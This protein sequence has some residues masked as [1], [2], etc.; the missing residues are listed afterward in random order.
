MAT[1]PVD[2]IRVWDAEVNIMLEP[3]PLP[4]LL[5]VE[6]N[7]GYIGRAYGER[8]PA[9][10]ADKYS[11]LVFMRNTGLYDQTLAMQNRGS[12]IEIFADDLITSNSEPYLFRVV[13]ERG[14]WWAFSLS[15][16]AVSIRMIDTWNP[17]VV[18]NVFENPEMVRD[19]MLEIDEGDTEV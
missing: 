19:G 3:L 18:G 17:R 10:D 14:C 1:N 12:S 9:D 8:K 16:G 6:W 2:R 13:Q 11:S 5:Q 4:K 7:Y 15:E